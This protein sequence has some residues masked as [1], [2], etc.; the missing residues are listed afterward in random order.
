MRQNISDKFLS[1]L[2]IALILDWIIDFLI[3]FYMSNCI[4]NIWLWDLIIS[5]GLILI[6]LIIYKW[7][8][9]KRIF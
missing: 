2:F 4:L 8:I 7:N 5:A 6:I 3:Y 1:M 9:S